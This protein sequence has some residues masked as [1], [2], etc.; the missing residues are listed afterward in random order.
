MGEISEK[1]PQ[2]Q[3]LRLEYT[4]KFQGGFYCGEECNEYYQLIDRVFAHHIVKSPAFWSKR[5]PQFVLSAAGTR[6]ISTSVTTDESDPGLENGSGQYYRFKPLND[7]DYL[8]LRLDE[9]VEDQDAE[10]RVSLFD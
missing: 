10:D 7:S 1:L 6:F 5:Q 4:R 3:V 9:E 8:D 2:L